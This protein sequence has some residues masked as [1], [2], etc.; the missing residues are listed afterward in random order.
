MDVVDPTWEEAGEGPRLAPVPPS[1]EGCRIGLL[2]NTKVGTARLYDHLAGLL[3]ERGAAEVVRVTKG[4]MSAPA[5]PDVLS[6][7]AAL[8][9]VLSGVGD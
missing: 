9:L 7:L 4:N 8:D 3:R 5:E 6:G 2:D 1:L